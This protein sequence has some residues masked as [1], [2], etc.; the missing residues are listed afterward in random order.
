MDENP[1]DTDHDGST[2]TTVCGE[3]LLLEPGR[4]PSLRVPVCVPAEVCK[5]DEK[6]PCVD[7]S[8]GCTCP[9][10]KACTVV[11]AG[12]TTFCAIPGNGKM[13]DACP[14]A[15]GY[16]CSS[17]NQCV[18]MCKTTGVEDTKTKDPP[19]AS[20]APGKCQATVGFPDGFG[21]CVGTIQ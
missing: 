7:G 19:L 8:Q 21:V 13:G 2:G 1:C 5:L 12:G 9:A 20:C 11:P 4:P 17:Q 3:R 14:C 10:D 15:R 6:Y 16:F 18:R